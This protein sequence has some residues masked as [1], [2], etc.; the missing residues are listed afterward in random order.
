VP[1]F[2]VVEAN[3]TA[4]QQVLN[5]LSAEVVAVHAIANIRFLVLAVALYAARIVEQL[6]DLDLFSPRRV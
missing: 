3:D 4:V 1:V 2:A 6:F 5:V